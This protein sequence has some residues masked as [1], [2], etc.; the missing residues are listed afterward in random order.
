MNFQSASAY[1]LGTINE[2][3]SRRVPYRLDRMRAFLHELGDPQE[4]YPTMH[5]GGTS[6]KGSTATMIAAALSA[7]GKR[8]GL[9]TKPHLASITER[10]RID[11]I[12]ISE[13][14]LA[15]RL[16]EMLPAIARVSAEFSKPSYY[17][18]LLALAFAYFASENVDIAVIEVGI[19]GKLDGTNVLMPQVSVI[20]NVG[21]DHTDILGETVEEI[22]ADKVGIAKPGVP[23]VSAVG[24]GSA[25]SVIQEGAARAGAPFLSVKD[26]VQI[27]RVAGQ[28]YGQEFDV[29]TPLDTYHVRLPVLG[30]FQETNAATAILALEQLPCALRPRPREVENGLAHVVLPGRMEF[31]PSHPSVIFDVAHNADKACQ[32][33]ESLGETFAGRRFSFVVAI[34]VSKDAQRILSA[35]ATLPGSFIFTAFEVPGRS[36]MKPQRLASIAQDLGIWGRA[37]SDPVEALAIARRNADASDVVV[38]TGSTF[39]VADLRGWWL[40]NVSSQT[41]A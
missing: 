22:A 20:T 30:R 28:I 13:E 10:A 16:T 6:G 8:C 18:T 7:G 31:F 14:A 29:R 41:S 5:I 21:L 24:A 17:E 39:V 32:L 34:A 15:E 1:L 23:L 11:G 27:H 2:T 37:V 19:G 3:V 33:V 4:R 9:H 40:D 35:L 38:V 12:A 26:D 36:A 25:R